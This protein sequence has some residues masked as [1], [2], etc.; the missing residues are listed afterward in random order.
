MEKLTDEI[1]YEAIS[2]VIDPEVGF[3]LVELGLIYG[4]A[5]DGENVK[6]TMTLST[7]GCP[8]HQAMMDW[9]KRP[10]RG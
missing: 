2:T 10:W 1:V 6:V 4:V 7:R 5:I 9:V 8:L 3:N